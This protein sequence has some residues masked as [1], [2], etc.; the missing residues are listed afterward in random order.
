[1]IKIIVAKYSGLMRQALA[2]RHKKISARPINDPDVVA[3]RNTLESSFHAFVQWSWPAIE[4][5]HFI[6]NWH[7]EALCKHLELAAE[8]KISNLIINIPPGTMKSTI[9]SM[10]NAWVWTRDPSLRFLCLSGSLGLAIKD[11]NRCKRIVESAEYQRLWGHKVILRKNMN[12]KLRC[13]TTAH[14]YRYT[15]SFGGNIRG[16]G[17]N[18]ILIDDGNPDIDGRSDTTREARND[19]LDSN[20]YLRLR[21]SNRICLINTQQRIHQYDLTGHMLSKDVPTVHIR[22]PMEFEVDH[23]CQT[24]PLKEGEDLWRD[25]RTQEGELLWPNW[26]D[27]EAVKR[28]KIN[29]RTP[30]NVSSQLQQRPSP[31]HGGII[32]TEWFK[33]WDRVSPPQR[34]YRLQSWD[35]AIMDNSDACYSACTTWDVFQDDD[36]YNNLYLAWCWRGKLEYPDLKDKIIDLRDKQN[37]DMILIEK[38]A[39]GMP[40]VQDLFRSGIRVTPFEPRHHGFKNTTGNVV[41]A[42]KE[43]RATIASS[44]IEDGLVWIPLDSRTE[45]R[46]FPPYVTLFLEAT[47]NFPRGD[48]K[49]IVDSMSQA[50]L[51]LAQNLDLN[52]RGQ[53]PD[54]VHL[55][56]RMQARREAKMMETA[57][58]LYGRV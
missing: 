31:R 42:S 51:K 2:Y 43:A 19:F 20:V 7:I 1:M 34:V 49:D 3:L 53:K 25:P 41:D 28:I 57:S 52:Y 21:G 58:N 45:F 12:T 26:L 50:I 11:S 29:L 16:E 40:L 9:L 14:G 39:N 35:T 55:D 36:G 56:W 18:F 54:E 33:K 30:Y 13:E 17:G 4:A 37:P 32:K 44:Y 48:G 22:L 46:S 5:G 27:S 10:F 47:M 23:V 6:N 24:I 15:F 38:G 8:F